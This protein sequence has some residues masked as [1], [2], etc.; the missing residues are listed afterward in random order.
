VR[1]AIAA[2]VVLVACG[3]GGG[4]GPSSRDALVDA[5][6]KAGLET[7]TFSAAQ[8][9]VGKDCASGTVNK[10]DVLVCSYPTP[11]EAKAAQDAGLQWVGDTTGAAQAK[12]TFLIAVA[13][14][15]KADPNGKTIN[16]ILKLAAN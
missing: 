4:A 12:G 15:R 1:G 9:P 7:S 14:R 13:D 16:Q 8:S 11:N 5:W 10:I 6:K 3:K 2:V